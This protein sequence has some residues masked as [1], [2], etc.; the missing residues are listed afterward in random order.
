MSVEE[1]AVRLVSDDQSRTTEALR[2]QAEQI[3]R[4]RKHANDHGYCGGI[5]YS[6]CGDVEGQCAREVNHD[7]KCK[8]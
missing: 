4:Y 3:A 2:K 5:V 8:P 7:G 1:A 6:H